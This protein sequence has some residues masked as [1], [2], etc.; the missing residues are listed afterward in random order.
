MR[1]DTTDTDTDTTMAVKVADLCP[2]T[3]SIVDQSGDTGLVPSANLAGEC[4]TIFTFTILRPILLSW[5]FCGAKSP[6]GRL[7]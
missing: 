1:D 4:S 7:L 6:P 3:S 2:W 5:A